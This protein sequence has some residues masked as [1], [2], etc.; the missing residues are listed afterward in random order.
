[1]K[2]K[3]NVAIR[4]PISSAELGSSVTPIQSREKFAKRKISAVGRRWHVVRDSTGPVTANR[5]VHRSSK[6]RCSRYLPT[7]IVHR[8]GRQ[9]RT[10]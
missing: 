9:L 5:G 10:G 3:R 8:A 7:L 1:M 2:K 4:R 6:E